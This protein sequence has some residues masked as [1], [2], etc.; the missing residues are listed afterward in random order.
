MIKYTTIFTSH[1]TYEFTT[2]FK[3]QKIYLS[4]VVKISKSMR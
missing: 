2:G 3:T 1:L 4:E